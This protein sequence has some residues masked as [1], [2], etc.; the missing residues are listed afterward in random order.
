VEYMAK[1]SQKFADLLAE[2]RDPKS[3]DLESEVLNGNS[4]RG[5]R[6]FAANTTNVEPLSAAPAPA[7]TVSHDDDS[8]ESSE[9][10]PITSVAE[11]DLA[12]PASK[13]PPVAPAPKQSRSPFAVLVPNAVA[14]E[15][16]RS[17]QVANLAPAS[18]LPTRGPAD[19]PAT[20]AAPAVYV[21]IGAFQNEQNAERLRNK[22]A[23]IAGLNIEKKTNSSGQILFHVRMGPFANTQESNQALQA[24]QNAGAEAKIVKN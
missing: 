9:F 11:T 6:Q 24:L 21:Q 12:P 23:T 19:P 7:A 15:P 22:Y 1:E 5:P 18:P 3:I 4:D 17:Q 16:S 20:P 2:G 14:S 8:I 10:A 13:N